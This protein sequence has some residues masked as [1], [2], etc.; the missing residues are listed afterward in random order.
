MSDIEIADDVIFN[1]E[2]MQ[3]YKESPEDFKVYT[4]GLRK[5]VE[6]VDANQLL[7]MKNMYYIPSVK[8]MQVTVKYNTSYASAPDG[9]TLPL[10]LDLRDEENRS[11]DNYFYEYGDKNGYA[12]IRI[13]FADVEFSETS[14]YILY[15]YLERNG[16][17]KQIGKFIMQDSS[18]ACREIKLTKKN[19]PALFE[20]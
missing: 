14:E 13:S 17:D 11:Y 6:S 9:K 4:Y 20:E 16:E 5:R 8:Q 15:V 12:Y 18:S 1:D 10:K 3:I 19:A 7:Q 2:I